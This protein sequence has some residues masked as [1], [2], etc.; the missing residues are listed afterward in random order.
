MVDWVWHRP[1]AENAGCRS[2]DGGDMVGVR[3]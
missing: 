3:D 1:H 2:G